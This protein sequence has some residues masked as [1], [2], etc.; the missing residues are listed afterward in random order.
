LQNTETR[1]SHLF[2][3]MLYYSITAFPE[4][5]QALLDFFDFVDLQLILM[6]LQT[7]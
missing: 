4:F 5:N 1:K 7:P 3:Q 2:T 6:L